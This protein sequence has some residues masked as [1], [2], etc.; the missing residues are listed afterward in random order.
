MD[1][2]VLDV[3]PE[4]FWDPIVLHDP[5]KLCDAITHNKAIGNHLL[6]G[7]QPLFPKSLLNAIK[8]GRYIGV[9]GNGLCGIYSVLAEIIQT[10]TTFSNM[11][12][13]FLMEQ[14]TPIMEEYGINNR[15]S[16]I[17][18]D[19]LCKIMRTYIIRYMNDDI[20]YPSFAIFSLSDLTVKFDTTYESRCFMNNLI[21]IVYNHGHF[22][23]LIYSQKQKKKIYIELQK[24]LEN[25]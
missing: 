4:D 10:N 16:M 8:N 1:D 7:F 13:E 19:I 15:P 6:S 3:I 12:H 2:I 18:V 25:K 11:D 22:E 14:M 9:R 24:F 17:D 23:A 21:T 20:E 5:K